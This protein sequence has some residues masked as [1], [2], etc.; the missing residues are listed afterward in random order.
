MDDKELS[1]LQKQLKEAQDGKEAAERELKLS[2]SKAE[3]ADAAERKLK[4]LEAERHREKV[5]MRRKEVLGTLESAVKSGEILPAAKERFIKFSKLN[6]DTVLEVTD[7]EVAEY[8]KENRSARSTGAATLSGNPD[9][10]PV[11]A[12]PD[13]E[14]AVRVARYCRDH[15]LKADV[16]GDQ[17][18]ATLAILRTDG[19]FAVKYKNLYAPV[20]T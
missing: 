16:Y 15:A 8:I 7:R 9:M 19:E 4:E 11:D 14:L 2:Q 20:S 12:M 13:D 1:A 18:K 5:E 6:T 3:T 10:L 17:I